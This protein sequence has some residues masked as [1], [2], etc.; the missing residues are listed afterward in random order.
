[1]AEKKEDKKVQD[2]VDEKQKMCPYCGG[3]GWVAV[4]VGQLED[5]IP[6]QRTGFVPNK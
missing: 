2:T 4:D 5:C 3:F 1:M 6:C